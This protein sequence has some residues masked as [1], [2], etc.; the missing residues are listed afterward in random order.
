MLI[1]RAILRACL[2]LDLGKVCYCPGL[3]ALKGMY[4]GL[5]FLI[6]IFIYLFGS[7]S[8]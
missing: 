4:S 3:H 8:P 7:A 6:F 1:L 2:I 5:A